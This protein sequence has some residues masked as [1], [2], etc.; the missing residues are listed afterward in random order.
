MIVRHFPTVADSS[1]ALAKD[2]C[3]WVDGFTP[4]DKIGLILPGGQSPIEL[5]R[6]L[7]DRALSWERIAVTVTDERVV[8]I[9][10]ASSNTG[11]VRRTLLQDRASEARLI[12]WFED[13]LS[14]PRSALAKAASARLNCYPWERSFLVLGTGADG[15]IASIFPGSYGMDA[16]GPVV[17]AESPDEP[18]ARLT[19]TWPAILN[20]TRLALL[21]HGAEKRLALDGAR[22]GAADTPLAHLLSSAQNLVL[23]V[24]P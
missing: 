17:S 3:T 23:Y 19:L 9:N 15:H 20:A 14:E 7:S 2:I 4:T 12:A 1:T 22:A 10:S 5:M 6:Q 18:S 8:P 13:H 11:Q 16:I 21:V 24:A